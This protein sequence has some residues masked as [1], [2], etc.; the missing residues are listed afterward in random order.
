MM[1]FWTLV[2][3][4]MNTVSIFI[5]YYEC[6][7]RLRAIEEEQ[8][9]IYAIEVILLL[10]LLLFFFKAYPNRESERG[11]ICSI[12]GLCGVCKA[13]KPNKKSLP[14]GNYE[15]FW[16]M[17]FKKVAIR[18]LS[19]NFLI[20]FLSVVPFFIGKIISVNRSYKIM[21]EQKHM[22]VFAYLRL[23]RITQLP[24]ILNASDV[25]ANIFMRKFPS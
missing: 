9:W 6:A 19:G 5:V 17:S 10:E 20:D 15:S 23:L 18:Y 11:W 14:A 7:F 1:M 13:K 2:A 16:Q 25:Y 4:S 21:L 8:S 12:L 24:K 22:M 3:L